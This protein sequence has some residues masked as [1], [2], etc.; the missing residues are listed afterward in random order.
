MTKQTSTTALFDLP[1]RFYEPLPNGFNAELANEVYKMIQ[2]RQLLWDQGVWR[3]FTILGDSDQPWR[4]D[5]AEMMGDQDSTQYLCGTSMC[6]AGWVNEIT[7][8]D[9]VV[10]KRLVDLSSSQG[11]T[12]VLLPSEA[13]G[14]DLSSVEDL[15]LMPK[16]TSGYTEQGRLRTWDRLD[17][18]VVKYLNRRGFSYDTHV[19]DT[20]QNAA[21]QALGL[22]EGDPLELFGGSKGLDEIRIIIDAYTAFGPCPT[23]DQQREFLGSWKVPDE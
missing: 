9:W 1:D 11:S 19:V 17:F 16:E 13:D 8:V 14:I 5:M 15:V 10:D 4:R 22:T 12:F 20:V 2:D 23:E 21:L 7:R 18:P 6:F 3:S